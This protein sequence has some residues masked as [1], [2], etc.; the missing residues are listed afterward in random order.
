MNNKERIN[1]AYEYLRYM[2]IIKTQEDVA[3]AMGTSRS[4]VSAALSGKS[5]VLTDSFI[6]RFAD[7][8]R[9]YFNRRWLLRE[10]GQ[11]LINKET[12]NATLV[13]GSIEADAL[14]LAARLI[15]STEHLRQELHAELEEVRALRQQLAA[16]LSSYSSPASLMV[17]EPNTK[18]NDN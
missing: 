8:F 6:S 4:N 3:K 18:E 12:G 2:R 1:A 10:E 9:E 15:E 17:A 14:T 13:G 5:S 11:M 16:L 7:A